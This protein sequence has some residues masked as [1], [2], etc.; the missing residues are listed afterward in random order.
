VTKERTKGEPDPQTTERRQ[1]A[2][3]LGT[4]GWALFLIW[5]GI[6]FLADVGVGVGLLGVGLVALGVQAARSRYELGVE[7]FWVF[8]GLMFAAGGVWE[9][10]G[11]EPEFPLVPI[12]FV[13]GGLALLWSVVRGRHPRSRP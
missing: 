11:I 13:V 10:L 2:E 3:K 12:F 6:A 8:I 1:L 5:V 9:L 7:G 4:A